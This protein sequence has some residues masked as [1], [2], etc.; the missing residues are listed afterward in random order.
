MWATM[1]DGAFVMH[2]AL[3]SDGEVV[4]RLQS[5]SRATIFANHES[6]K[7]N[8]MQKEQLIAKYITDRAQFPFE[9]V[10]FTQQARE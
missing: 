7:A 2:I 3:V 8:T 10:S 6:I 9:M 5:V 1:I 4:E